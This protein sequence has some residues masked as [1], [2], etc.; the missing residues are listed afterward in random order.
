MISGVSP[1]SMVGIRGVPLAGVAFF[2]TLCLSL[3]LLIY[4]KIK[5]YIF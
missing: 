2:E 4:L 5:N 3:Y 1:P